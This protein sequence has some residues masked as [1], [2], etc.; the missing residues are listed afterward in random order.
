VI[1]DL[2]RDD[3]SSEVLVL[4]DADHLDEATQQVAQI[5]AEHVRDGSVDGVTWHD[6]T[7]G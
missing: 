7:P 2:V 1:A 3:E 5:L 6:Q 4:V